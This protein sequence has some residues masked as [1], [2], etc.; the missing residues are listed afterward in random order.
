MLILQ[1]TYI[2]NMLSITVVV[3]VFLEWVASSK[4]LEEVEGLEPTGT[5]SNVRPPGNTSSSYFSI[6]GIRTACLHASLC[7]KPF[8]LLGFSTQDPRVTLLVTDTNLK[9]ATTP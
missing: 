9:E 8:A 7:C 6:L 4:A 2:M 3:Y 5:T 1:N